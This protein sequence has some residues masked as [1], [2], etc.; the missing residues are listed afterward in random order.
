MLAELPQQLENVCKSVAHYQRLNGNTTP[1]SITIPER[2]QILRARKIGIALAHADW[3]SAEGRFIVYYFLLGRPWS[4]KHVE[5]T[6]VTTP[7]ELAALIGRLFDSAQCAPLTYRRMA[8]Q[9]YLWAAWN[10]YS[11]IRSWSDAVNELD[12]PD[13]NPVL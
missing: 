2:L 9:W 5:Q 7:N 8:S 11:I 6:P 13:D 12:H 4:S 1:D 10:L 3:S